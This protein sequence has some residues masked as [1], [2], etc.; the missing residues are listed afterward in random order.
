MQLASVPSAHCVAYS[1]GKFFIMLADQQHVCELSLDTGTCT[2]VARFSLHS[3]EMIVNFAGGPGGL[4]ILT[5]LRG[6]FLATGSSDTKYIPLDS[7]GISYE[8]VTRIEVNRIPIF[9]LE[10][11]TVVT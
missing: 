4:V 11:N 2:N 8:S 1:D 6:I 3:N 9:Y 10:N 7:A 5:S